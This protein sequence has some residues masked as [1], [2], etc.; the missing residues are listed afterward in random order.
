MMYNI[1]VNKKQL[2]IMNQALHNFMRS[3]IGQFQYA[4]DNWNFQNLWKSGLTTL[5]IEWLEE[6]FNRNELNQM[7]GHT[8]N[9][10]IAFDLHQVFRHQLWK[11]NEN[12]LSNVCD[13]VT[14]FGN[15]KL[16]KIEVE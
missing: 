6:L 13:S 2:E 9:S 11:E 8:E 16:A 1:K 14:K 7:F 10:E 12:R 15:E 3:E 4:F 5:Q